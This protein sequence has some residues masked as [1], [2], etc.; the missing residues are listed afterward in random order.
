MDTFGPG[1]RI[2]IANIILHDRISLAVLLWSNN[3]EQTGAELGKAQPQL[4]LSLNN[5]EI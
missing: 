1:V 5:V 4:G 3:I 2:L